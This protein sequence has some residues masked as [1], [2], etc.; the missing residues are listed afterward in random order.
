MLSPAAAQD[1]WD[2]IEG[3]G[4]L[5]HPSFAGVSLG[6]LH[7]AQPDALVLCHD[8]SRTFLLGAQERQEFP[9]LPVPETIEHCLTF[10]RRVN[11]KARFV[12]MSV[13]SASL[14]DAERADVFARYE[15]ET[16]LPVADPIKDGMARIVDKLLEE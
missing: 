12:G 8:P 3:Q 16:G 14:S 6:L 11:P 4:A 1:H 9:L 15:R 2:V 10:A 7:G 5:S 13:N